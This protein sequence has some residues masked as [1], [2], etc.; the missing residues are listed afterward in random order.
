MVCNFPAL[1]AMVDWY[2]PRSI[3]TYRRSLIFV[4]LPTW[5]GLPSMALNFKVHLALWCVE[6]L[7][8]EKNSLAVND[9]IL[10]RNTI[11]P[12]LVLRLRRFTSINIMETGNHPTN[13]PSVC[14]EFPRCFFLP[15]FLF[16]LKFLCQL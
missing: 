10:L 4:H 5:D 3:P 8:F 2:V 7:P 6:N 11:Y 1:E 12:Y 9:S 15:P 14:L 16:A 13:P